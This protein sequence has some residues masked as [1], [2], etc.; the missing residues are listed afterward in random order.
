MLIG[1]VLPVGR[2][3]PLA[4]TTSP[5]EEAARVEATEERRK[6]APRVRSAEVRRLYEIDAA[7]PYWAKREAVRRFEAEIKPLR[8]PR[9]R[10]RQR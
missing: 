2:R 9:G 3:K 6:L 5:E 10:P 8:I 1:V 7:S 4:Y